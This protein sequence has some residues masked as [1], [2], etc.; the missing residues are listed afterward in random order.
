MGA[1]RKLIGA[2][3]VVLCTSSAFGAF[4]FNTVID[5]HVAIPSG[6][7]DPAGFTYAGSNQVVMGND[8]SVASVSFLNYGSIEQPTQITAVTLNLTAGSSATQIVART[9]DLTSDGSLS[10]FD[11]STEQ[12]D[13]FAELSISSTGGRAITFLAADTAG[14]LGVYQATASTTVDG[15]TAI[16]HDSN[17]ST[18]SLNTQ[19][20]STVGLQ[21]VHIQVNDSGQVSYQ[22]RDTTSTNPVDEQ[23]FVLTG[24]SPS[25]VTDTTN[26]GGLRDF[27]SLSGYATIY[28]SPEFRR[29]AVTSTGVAV[30]RAV[31]GSSDVNFYRSTNLTN[32][33]LA[34]DSTRDGNS[35]KLFSASDTAV[36]YSAEYTVPSQPNEIRL[37]VQD[38]SG[39][40]VLTTYD[41]Q[42]QFGGTLNAVMTQDNHVAYFAP[43]PTVISP[44]SVGYYYNQY[45]H[46]IAT[47]DGASTAEGYTINQISI[48]GNTNPMV[49]TLGTVVFDAVIGNEADPSETALILWRESSPDDL[50]IIIKTGDLY[51]GNVITGISIDGSTNQAGDVLK[52]GLSDT[53][54]LAFGITYSEYNVDTAQFEDH[55]A[56]LTVQLPEPSG[57]ALLG[58]AGAATLSRRRRRSPLATLAG[59]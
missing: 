18:Y 23:S 6:I 5:D 1:V 28:G 25:S 44:A 56:L 26:A 50:K 12:F 55:N 33:L 41:P 29:I 49:N 46:T 37:T 42:S 14:Q 10:S 4:Q 16:Q 2:S 9:G 30:F 53:N 32:P 43:G 15:R 21:Q 22:R 58:L 39:S 59:T 20:P 17:A 51:E 19:S 45:S 27:N 54:W 31:D 8:G 11:G 24:G 3:S 7:V 36:L 57:L 52:D 13:S 35:L 48:T 34:T 38:G 40:H 47:A